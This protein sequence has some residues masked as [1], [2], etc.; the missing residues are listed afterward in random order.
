MYKDKQDKYIKI[1]SI[2]DK[3]GIKYKIKK[4]KKIN[5]N[6]NKQR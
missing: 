6:K 4:L 1:K 2:T 3:K 5:P